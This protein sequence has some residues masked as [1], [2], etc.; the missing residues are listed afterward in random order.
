MVIF[1]GFPFNKPCAYSQ[2]FGKTFDKILPAVWLARKPVVLWPAVGCAFSVGTRFAIAFPALRADKIIFTAKCRGARLWRAVHAVRTGRQAETWRPACSYSADAGQPRCEATLQPGRHRCRRFIRRGF[3]RR[4]YRP[5]CSWPSLRSGRWQCRHPQ[6]SSAAQKPRVRCWPAR[7]RRSRSFN[8]RGRGG[9]P[10]SGRC[11]RPGCRGFDG[12]C[13]RGEVLK[14][15]ISLLHH[16]RGRAYL[17]CLQLPWPPCCAVGD[18]ARPPCI[19]CASPPFSTPYWIWYGHRVSHWGVAGTAV[20]TVLSHMHGVQRRIHVP[21]LSP[22]SAKG[23]NSCSIGE[24]RGVSET[25]HPPPCC[26][27]ASWP[28]A[29]CSCG[30]W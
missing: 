8:R 21:P 10:S 27:R 7:L 25:G 18:N 19:F 1:C 12:R 16:L 22:C 29:A 13:R 15:G 3:G 20:A 9:V 2:N 14:L 4:G 28:S 24:G 5:L 30:G 23:A 6:S 11:C 26:S 17:G